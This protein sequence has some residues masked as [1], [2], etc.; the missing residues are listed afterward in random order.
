MTT[1]FGTIYGW[2]I[3]DLSVVLKMFCIEKIESVLLLFFPVVWF[4]LVIDSGVELVC[5]VLK[6]LAST[7]GGS[8]STCT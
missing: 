4:E 6:M 1:L 3:V 8:S 2:T 7:P 5:N